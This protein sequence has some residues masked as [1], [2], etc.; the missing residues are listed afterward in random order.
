MF[1]TVIVRITLTHLLRAPEPVTKSKK[2]GG[3]QRT[4]RAAT[5]VS[6]GLWQRLNFSVVSAVLGYTYSF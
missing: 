5:D 4:P 2:K 1:E 3:M 6:P